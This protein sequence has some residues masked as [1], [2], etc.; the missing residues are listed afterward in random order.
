MQTTVITIGG[1]QYLIGELLPRDRV[2][3]DIVRNVS[4][5]VH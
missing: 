2:N 3:G 4:G 5:A 1:A